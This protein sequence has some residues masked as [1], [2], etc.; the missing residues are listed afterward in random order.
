M[1][2]KLLYLWIIYRNASSRRTLKSKFCWFLIL[3][4]VCPWLADAGHPWIALLV[5]AGAFYFGITWMIQFCEFYTRP[6]AEVR[7]VGFFKGK[8]GRGLPQETGD[9]EFDQKARWDTVN[10]HSYLCGWSVPELRRMARRAGRYSPHA[11]HQPG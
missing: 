7:R 4:A 3:L 10:G 2:N 8:L 5:D 1:K 11:E 6:R 9:W